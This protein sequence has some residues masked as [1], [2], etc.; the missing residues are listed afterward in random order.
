METLLLIDGNALMHRA[1]FALP[2]FKTKSGTPTNAIYGFFTMLDRAIQDFRPDYLTVCFDTPKPTFRKKIFKEY[3]I[4]RPKMTQELGIQFPLVKQL[5]EKGGI[6]HEEKEGY[7]ADDVIGSITKTVKNPNLKVLILTGDKDIMQLIDGNVYVITPQI[8]FSKT[9]IY[10]HHG[11][12]EKFGVEPEQIPDLKALAGD[13]SD[14]Y[15]GAKGIGPKTASK[16]IQEF[17]SI[18]NLFRNLESIKDEKLKKILKK[19]KK[20]ILLCKKLAQL[21][22]NVKITFRKESAKFHGFKK[23]LK[24]GLLAFEMR[25]LA[26]RFFGEPKKEPQKKKVEPFRDQ[27]NL[28]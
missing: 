2:D 4:Q 10:D 22:T 7:E 5:L 9:K 8:G 28:F 13:P 19:N 17:H 21:V 12:L 16:L 11:V 20:N 27:I 6:F 26:E 18:E 14:N 23:E 3:Q 15:P 1:Y 24:D 25:S